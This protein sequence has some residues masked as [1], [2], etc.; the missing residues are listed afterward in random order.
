MSKHGHSGIKLDQ[1]GFSFN[2]KSKSE[3]LS[4]GKHECLTVCENRKKHSI[5]HFVIW[6][7]F[8]LL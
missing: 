2:S 4:E 3:K 1:A 5:S 6:Q 8:T 7:I